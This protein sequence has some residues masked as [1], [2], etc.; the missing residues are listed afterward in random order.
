MM[1]R[2]YDSKN[3]S[4]IPISSRGAAD[5]TSIIQIFIAEFYNLQQLGKRYDDIMNMYLSIIKQEKLR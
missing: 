1:H 3:G 5:V 4:V 2:V